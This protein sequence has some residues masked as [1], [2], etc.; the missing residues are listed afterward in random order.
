ML[1][2]AQN[3]Q[4]L[5][6]SQGILKCWD[7]TVLLH[8]FCTCSFSEHTSSPAVRNLLPYTSLFCVGYCQ[9]GRCSKD[10]LLSMKG[11][12]RGWCC[13]ASTSTYREVCIPES[14]RVRQAEEWKSSHRVS[15]LSLQMLSCYQLFKS[16]WAVGNLPPVH[17]SNSRK[18][19]NSWE[20]GCQ[21]CACFTAT[22]L[23]TCSFL[24]K[25]NK[26]KTHKNQTCN[27]TLSLPC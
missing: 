7:Y 12:P 24:L 18:F 21:H 3:T 16:F 2:K 17:V 8:G 9:Q 15:M 1:Q 5:S 25:Q 6:P 10:L 4:R 13:S 26:T 14:W 22:I 11:T 27:H 19:S 23:K 20:E